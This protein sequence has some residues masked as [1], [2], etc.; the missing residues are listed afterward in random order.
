MSRAISW[1][2]IRRAPNSSSTGL[3]IFPLYYANDDD[4]LRQAGTDSRIVFT[5][6]RD[7]A[8]LVAVSDSRGLGGER[9][10]YDLT[11]REPRQDYAVALNGLNAKIPAGSGQPFTLSADRRDG[12][13]GDI[14]VE[15]SGVPAGWKIPSP[16]VIE[17]GHQEARGTVNALANA[18]TLTAAEAAQIKLTATAAIGGQKVTRTIPAPA[19]LTL[20]PAPDLLVALE[21]AAAGDTLA[22]VSPATPMQTQ[23][24]AK[25]FEITIAPGETIPAWIKIKRTEKTKTADIRFDVENLPHG[26]IVDNLGLNGITLLAGQNEGEIHIKCDPWVQEMTRSCF[27]LSRG[28]GAQSSLPVLLHVKK[29]PAQKVTA[30]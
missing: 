20:A 1:S 15:I 10:T 5:A 13:D 22:K 8:Y 24:P 26:V 3:P 21:P 7:G 4:G 6:P 9:Y 19:P 12:F 16:L 17:A 23:D 2:R 11:I 14:T 27:A 25:P 30:R 28:N 18:K 29:K